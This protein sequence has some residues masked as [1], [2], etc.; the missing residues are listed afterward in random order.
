MAY[1]YELIQWITDYASQVEDL[2]IHKLKYTKGLDTKSTVVSFIEAFS[3]QVQLLEDA[4]KV[5]AESRN[6]DTA[7]GEQL[8]VLGVLLE[9]LRGSLSDSSY[10]AMLKFKVDRNR[11]YGQSSIL[12][13]AIK[14]VTNSSAV[15]ILEPGLATVDITFDGTTIPSNLKHLTSEVKAAAVEVILNSTS[16]FTPFGFGSASGIG[17]DDPDAIGFA[18]LGD[19]VDPTAGL[20]E[21]IS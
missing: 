8:D 9:E 12:Y 16:G 5:Q 7:Y 1:N 6:I 2:I 14:T 3:E 15:F 18:E 20:T 13:S 21:L 19:P 10:R 17:E 4:T 11:S